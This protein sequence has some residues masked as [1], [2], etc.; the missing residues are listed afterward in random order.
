MDAAGSSA[1]HHMLAASLSRCGRNPSRITTQFR[2][3]GREQPIAEI[4]R[5]PFVLRN[6]QHRQTHSQAFL[7][8]QIGLLEHFAELGHDLLAEGLQALDQVGHARDFRRPQSTRPA[9]RRVPAGQ[10]QPARGHAT[11]LRSRPC[12]S[13]RPAPRAARLPPTAPPRRAAAG[14][15]ARHVPI[16]RR[17]GQG[18]AGL[19]GNAAVPRPTPERSHTAAGPI[20][21]GTSARSFPGREARPR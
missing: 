21:P 1:I 2:R 4:S 14:T 5:L 11:C 8:A 19:A 7:F 15:T 16:A 9:P 17:G 13:R 12:S 20:S 10:Q 18:L 6:H 3:L